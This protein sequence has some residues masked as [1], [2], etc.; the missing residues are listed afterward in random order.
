LI[1]TIVSS[2]TIIS[3]IF[4]LVIFFRRRYLYSS[5]R[6]S[7]PPQYYQDVWCELGKKWQIHPKNIILAEKIGQ[8][9]FGDV[10]RGELK[11]NDNK[12]IEVAIKVLRDQN[13]AS[14]HEFLF[15]ANRM[16]DFSHKWGS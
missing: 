7:K 2:L 10:Y 14:M 8:G 3:L 11:E 16:K 15:E 12:L 6:S 9:C 5:E 4:L 1:L 13:V